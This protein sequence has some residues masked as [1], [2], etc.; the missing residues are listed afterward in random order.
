MF[1]LRGHGNASGKLQPFQMRR[2]FKRLKTNL[3]KEND[4]SEER[5]KIAAEIDW[6]EEHCNLKE[7]VAD[8]LNSVHCQVIEDNSNSRGL[9]HI[10]CA[11]GWCKSCPKRKRLKTEVALENAK[12]LPWIRFHTYETVLMCTE[13][14]ALND[15]LTE[16]S[17]CSNLEDGEVCGKITRARKIVRK[18]LPF[19]V[20]YK[21]Y[22]LKTLL[23]FKK[24]RFLYILLSRNH[25]GLDRE[26]ITT[27]EIHTNRD[28]AER[29]T[30]M[31]NQQCQHEYFSGR[32]TISIEG[33]SVKYFPATG[34]AKQMDFHT[35]LSDGKIQNAAVVNLNM[36][37]LILFL[38]EEG[39]L[40]DDSIIYCHSDGCAEQYRSGTAFYFLSTLALKYNI[41]ISR[42]IGCSGHGKYKWAYRKAY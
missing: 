42:F 29:L 7:T 19:S 30:L 12:N 18:H 15:N 24:H 8:A 9:N 36:E 5:K 40:V 4:G 39:V 33:V 34:G 26:N 23:L 6:Y 35:Y 17:V 32:A 22:Y 11:M 20:F 38:K 16:C 21:D 25:C 14:G 1:N 37:K 27:T 3:Q 2:H 41:T 10:D 13:H 28:F 31:F